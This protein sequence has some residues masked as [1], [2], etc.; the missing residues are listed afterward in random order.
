M[1]IMEGKGQNEKYIAKFTPKEAW[2]CIR[3]GHYVLFYL[4]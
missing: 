4:S 3:M 2:L 1:T